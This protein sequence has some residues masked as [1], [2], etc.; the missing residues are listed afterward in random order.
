MERFDPVLMAEHPDWVVVVGDVN[1]TIAAALVAS[2][3]RVEIGCRIAHVEAGLRSGD[4]R[5]PEEVNRV[6]TDQLSDLLLTH[7][8][9]AR[10]M[11]LREGIPSERIVD[12]GNVMIDSLFATLARASTDTPWRRFGLER[13]AYG[14]VTLHRP[15]NVD[16]PGPLMVLVEA[17]RMVS[18]DLPLLWPVHPRTRRQLDLLSLDTGNRLQLID[19]VGYRDM[20]CLQAG[21]RVVITDSGGL[22]E[23]ST[24]LGVPCVTLRESTERPITVTEGTNRLAPWPLTAA[25][26]VQTV[27]DAVAAGRGSGSRSGRPDGWDGRAAPRVVRALE[28]AKI[29][30]SRC[31]AARPAAATAV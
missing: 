31:G 2:K 30:D 12:V 16:D 1:S 17:L 28:E 14:L 7:S 13:E 29:A 10:P 21:A 22:Q 20:T 19:P 27:R 18:V 6:L 24:A 9:E 11:L 15:S 26:I 8:P 25:G 5:M 23:E 4:W 3:R